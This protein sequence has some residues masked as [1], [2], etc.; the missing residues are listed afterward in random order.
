LYKLEQ[1]SKDNYFVLNNVN[2][3]DPHPL[4]RIIP[5]EIEDWEKGNK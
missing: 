3:L 4:F 5:G 1:P 2:I